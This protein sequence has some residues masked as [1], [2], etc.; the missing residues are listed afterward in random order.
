MSN[1]IVDNDNANYSAYWLNQTLEK[2][3]QYT[4]GRKT[5]YNTE[6]ITNNATLKT[7]LNVPVPMNTA[8]YV[9]WNMCGWTQTAVG[10]VFQTGG[11]R[12]HN[13]ARANAN[14]DISAQTGNTVGSSIDGSFVQITIGSDNASINFNV[15][16][17]ATG[18]TYWTGQAELYFS[19]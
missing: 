6:G 5:I 3:G 16:G 15:V 11:F 14:T 4:I 9:S 13:V 18:A 10:N 2:N 17:G 8:I 19:P 12:C 1:Q 7:L